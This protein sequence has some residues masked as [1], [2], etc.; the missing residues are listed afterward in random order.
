M[1]LPAHKRL[2]NEHM[3][4]QIFSSVTEAVRAG[5][6]IESPYSDSEGFLH[7]RIHAPGGWTQALVRTKGAVR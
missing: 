3:G 6:I 2:E 1:L 5:F 7:A 4:I